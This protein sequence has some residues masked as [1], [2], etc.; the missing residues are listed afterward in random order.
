MS[1]LDLNTRRL[2][3]Y[4]ADQ[5]ASTAKEASVHGAPA[6]IVAITTIQTGA[7]LMAAVAGPSAVAILLRQM[8]AEFDDRAA[9]Q[10][11]N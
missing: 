3:A 4:V 1:D 8:A 7:H 2:V 5:A 9:G 11:N 6:I 10:G